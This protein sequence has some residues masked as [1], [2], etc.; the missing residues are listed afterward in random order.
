[1]P[2]LPHLLTSRRERED[3]YNWAI[4]GRSARTGTYLLA[5]MPP[6]H[7]VTNQSCWISKLLN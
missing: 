3:A 6:L 4:D 2:M 1:M 5:P 7:S